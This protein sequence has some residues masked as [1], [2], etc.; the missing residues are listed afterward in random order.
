M[1]S[2]DGSIQP[3]SCPMLIL[4]L[5]LGVSSDTDINPIVYG[6]SCKVKFEHL[7]LGIGLDGLLLC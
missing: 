3:F 7:A 2:R 4:I 5:L 1:A 6:M